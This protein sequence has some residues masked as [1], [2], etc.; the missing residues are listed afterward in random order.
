M[1]DL[2]NQSANA[3]AAR[4]N[5]RLFPTTHWSVVLHAG[6]GS[7]SQVHAALESLCR[8]YWYPLYA[9]VRR[10]GRSHHEAEDCTQEFLARLLASEGVARARPERGRF[11]N[12]LLVALRNFLTKEWHRTQAVKRGG[13]EPALSL[14]FDAGDRRFGHEPSDPGL[15]AEQM[16]DRNW[17]IGLIDTAVRELRVDYEKSGREPL[18][19]TLI[20]LVWSN[21]DPE[22][23]AQSAERLGMTVHALTMAL[24]R[25]RRRLGERLRAEVAETVADGT[26]VDAEL[27]H[28]IASVSHARG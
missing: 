27:R 23:V 24:H 13:G 19:A 21:D 22:G 9:F 17:A 28:L 7:E 26:D 25:L 1:A 15:T 6:A 3:A 4:P 8:Q 12:F 20:P 10:Q 11:R 16:F 5:G 14:D 18:F 2:Q